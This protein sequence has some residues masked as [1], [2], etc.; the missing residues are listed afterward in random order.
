MSIRHRQGHD[1]A[2]SYPFGPHRRLSRIDQRLIPPWHFIFFAFEIYA[3]I[4]V[5]PLH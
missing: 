4:V 2:G 5:P 1:L 3:L